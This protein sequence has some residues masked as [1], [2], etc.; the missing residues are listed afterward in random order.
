MECDD[1]HVLAAT[2]EDL[3]RGLKLF[4]KEYDRHNAV[5]E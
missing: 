2:S 5:Q 3:N 1:G 4:F